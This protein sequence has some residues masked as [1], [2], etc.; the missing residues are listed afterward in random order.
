M[1]RAT[2]RMRG[3][4]GLTLLEVLAATMIFALV[5]TVLVG[6][7]STAV[8]R[9]GLAARR[10]EANLLADAVV[11]DLEIQMRKKIAPVVEQTQWTTEDEEYVVHVQNRSIEAALA[12]P[13]ET[14]ADDAAGT[15]TPVRPGPGSTQIGAGSGIG[16]LLAGELPEVAKHLRQYDIEIVWIGA[17]GP[18]SVTRTTFAFDWQ[19]AQ[20]EYA[21]LFTAE[22]GAGDAGKTGD[23]EDTDP[24]GRDDE[25]GGQQ[26]P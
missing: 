21:A 13:A 6:T 1:K 23:D 16:T 19:A 22:G 17:D 26:V 14:L 4:R 15:A 25:R 2:E 11:A 3:E 20:L 24:D 12:A 18:E 5:M 10:L 7:S 9:S 8:H